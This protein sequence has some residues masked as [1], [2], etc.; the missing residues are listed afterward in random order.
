[1]KWELTV[2]DVITKE[3]Y[4]LLVEDNLNDVD[5]TKIAFKKCQV[6][7]KLEVVYDGQEALD[8]L[9]GQGK[10]ASRDT[11]YL[12]SV[13]LL[14]LKLPYIDGLEV[15]KQI[16]LNIQTSRIPVVVLS[17][18]INKDEINACFEVGINRY[19][20]KPERFDQFTKIIQE[21]QN[22]WLTGD[23]ETLT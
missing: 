3:K 1:M 22:T 12:P 7:N 19:C 20:R 9:F 23:S 15:L 18:S 5:L 13:I 8:F 6:F 4:V 21:I 11:S 10:Y 2:S 14:D 17:S 16:R